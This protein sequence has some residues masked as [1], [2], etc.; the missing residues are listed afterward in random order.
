MT[1]RFDEDIEYSHSPEH[2]GL[3]LHAYKKFFPNLVSVEYK[4]NDLVLQRRGID[5]E[6]KLRS[7][8][9]I[10]ID[11]KKRRNYYNDILVEFEDRGSPGW[12]NKNLDID[13]LAYLKAPAE[14]VWIFDWRSLVRAWQENEDVWQSTYP[15]RTS[16][17]GTLN[18]PVPDEILCRAVAEAGCASAIR[19]KLGN[20]EYWNLWLS[21]D[22]SGELAVSV[23]G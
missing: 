3:W 7:E 22:E 15:R 2:A 18:T 6:L 20:G 10:L 13:C 19:S 14:S 12:I 1:D 9:T 23:V 16:Y 5:V 11:E 4:E 17:D 8:E 21:N